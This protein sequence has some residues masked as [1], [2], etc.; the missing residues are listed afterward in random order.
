MSQLCR[1]AGA[2]SR[3]AISESPNWPLWVSVVAIATSSTND[4]QRQR[5]CDALREGYDAVI[6][7]WAGVYEGIVE[8][9]GLRLRAP[10]TI[11]QFAVAVTALSEGDSLR[12]HVDRAQSLVELPT[13]TDGETQEWTIY[14]LAVEAVALQFFEPDPDY[15]P[16]AP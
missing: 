2:A 11:H 6:G 8:F 14:S 13:G 3:E 1:V 7:Y 4:E 10:R 9:L 12:Q 16:P 5:M 15:V